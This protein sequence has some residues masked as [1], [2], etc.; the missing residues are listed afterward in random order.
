[1]PR[2]EVALHRKTTDYRLVM[3]EADDESGAR[4]RALALARGDATPRENESEGDWCDSIAGR[5]V[6]DKVEL[7]EVPRGDSV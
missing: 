2:Y 1:M 3:V 5:A 7:M 6:V 4:R